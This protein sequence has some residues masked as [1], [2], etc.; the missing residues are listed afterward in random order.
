[1][2]HLL[3]RQLFS[4]R[5]HWQQS[6]TP[7]ASPRTPLNKRTISCWTSRT[8]APPPRSS[9]LR[10]RSQSHLLDWPSTPTQSMSS[11]P[12]EASKERK[13]QWKRMKLKTSRAAFLSW[14]ISAWQ[15]WIGRSPQIQL[16]MR[17]KESKR[18]RLSKSLESSMPSRSLIISRRKKI[19]PAISGLTLI[20]LRLCAA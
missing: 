11:I 12:M 6:R 19:C 13:R 8:A 2:T 10:K 1:M 4:L 15:P 20:C 7:T 9:Q 3:T 14:Q 16:S 17:M 5:I 18:N